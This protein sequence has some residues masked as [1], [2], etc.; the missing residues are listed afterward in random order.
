MTEEFINKQIYQ[1]DKEREKNE[2]L[3]KKLIPVIGMAIIVILI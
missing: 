3:Y 2:K 1:A